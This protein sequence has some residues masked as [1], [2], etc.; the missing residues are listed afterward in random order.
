MPDMITQKMEV[1]TRVL[2]THTESYVLD[3]ALV[4]VTI[5]ILRIKFGWKY[6]EKVCNIELYLQM[7]LLTFIMI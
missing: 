6:L 4:P 5:L 2:P 7:F 3:M 1:S